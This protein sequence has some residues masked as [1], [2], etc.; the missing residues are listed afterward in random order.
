MAY[1]KQNLSTF[2]KSERLL[3]DWILQ[4][5]QKTT[6]LTI[7]GLSFLTHVSEPSI[8]RFCRT[9]GTKGYA[10]FKLQLTE[11]LAAGQ[12]NSHL[13]LDAPIAPGALRNH[14]IDLARQALTECKLELS[15]EALEYAI[16][17]L[18]SSPCVIIAALGAFESEAMNLY[19]SLW[20]KIKKIGLVQS[21]EQLNVLKPEL[22][23]SKQDLGQ[24]PWCFLIDDGSALAHKTALLAMELG[25]K[26]FL[27]GPLDSPFE[28]TA[29][30]AW[31]FSK[32]EEAFGYPLNFQMKVVASMEMLKHGFN[33]D[34]AGKLQKRLNTGSKHKKNPAQKVA[35]PVNLQA[36]LW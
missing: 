6:K 30:I 34:T 22:E 20:S 28:K 19:I 32:N 8:V 4:N 1:L 14:V 33:L 10:D 31:C 23:L 27:L 7:K 36:E 25:Y 26:L 2:R 16:Y 11:H 3:A 18:H 35:E 5:P 29:E 13:D 12:T 21:P 15:D 24:H 17:Q 9:V